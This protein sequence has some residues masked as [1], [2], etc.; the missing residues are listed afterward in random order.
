MSKIYG[1]SFKEGGK[2]YYFKGNPAEEIKKD[3]KVLV[4]TEKGTQFGKVVAQIN[5]KD[6]EIGDTHLKEILR[7]ATDEDYELY[8]KNL[9]DAVSALGNARKIAEELGLEM[10]ILSA[11]FTFDKKQLLFNFTADA[12][13]DF[14]ELARRLAGIYRTRIELRQIGARDKA[15]EIGGLG[16]CGRCLCCS[17]FLG[18]IDSISMNMAKNQGLVLNPSKI[19]GQCGRLLCCLT[20]END[21]YTACQEG[22]P[23]VGE[24]VKTDKGL[25]KV[26]SVDILNRKYKVDVDGDVVEVDLSSPKKESIE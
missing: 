25:G 4:L 23:E 12:R 21:E 20:Y 7:V 24:S 2:V 13:V 18:R 3:D 26:V 10:V 15:K 16:Q 19:N 22:M 17:S 6:I 9:S 11:S 5:E 1:I 14:R 8:L